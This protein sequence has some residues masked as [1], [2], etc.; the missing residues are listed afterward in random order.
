MWKQFKWTMSS[1]KIHPYD[2]D[3]IK[4]LRYMVSLENIKIV[5]FKI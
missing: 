1:G 4:I 3:I 2:W 5:W